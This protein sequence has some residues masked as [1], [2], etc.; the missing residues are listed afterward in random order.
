MEMQLMQLLSQTTCTQE[1]LR[2]QQGQMVS[3]ISSHSKQIN[4]LAKQLERME[5]TLAAKLSGD[6]DDDEDSL[7]NEDADAANA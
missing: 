2:N 3:A 4:D 7:S 5:S 6:A 1:Q